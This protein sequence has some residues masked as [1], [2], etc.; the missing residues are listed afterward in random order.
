MTLFFFKEVV[1]MTEHFN[2]VEILASYSGS[3]HSSSLTQNSVTPV[4]SMS[5][6]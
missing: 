4:L 3:S 6:L 2:M 1:A 5:S